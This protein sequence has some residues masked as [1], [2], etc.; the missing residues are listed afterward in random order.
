MHN[1]AALKYYY[2]NIAWAY[3]LNWGVWWFSKIGINQNGYDI[4]LIL[5]ASCD[6]LTISGV[7]DVFCPF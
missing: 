5:Q 3:Y 4:H 2:P 1:S 6:K 7:N